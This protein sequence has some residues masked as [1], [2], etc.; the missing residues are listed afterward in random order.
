ML[1]LIIIL[2]NKGCDITSDGN[3]LRITLRGKYLGHIC[4]SDNVPDDTKQ[5]PLTSLKQALEAL[6]GEQNEHTTT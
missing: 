2:R 1:D 6:L 3:S 4:N 5:I